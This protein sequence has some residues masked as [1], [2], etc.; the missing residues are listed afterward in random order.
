MNQTTSSLTRLEL[1]V[2]TTPTFRRMLRRWQRYAPRISVTA[3][4]R[5]ALAKG[6]GFLEILLPA[7]LG[8]RQPGGYEALHEGRIATDFYEQ[9]ASARL[10][11][12][13]CS[14]ERFR[15][16]ARCSVSLH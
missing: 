13:E 11:S 15:F 4:A 8:G 3:R 10:A 14:G 1:H 9:S 5:K 2:P 6:P 7:L 16:K 12:S